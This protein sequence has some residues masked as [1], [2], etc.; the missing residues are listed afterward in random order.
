MN[1]RN[2]I[3]CSVACPFCI[4]TAIGQEW[5]YKVAG[6]EKWAS[7]DRSFRACSAGDQ[8]SPIDLRGGVK[9]ELPKL[10]IRATKDRLN[11]WNNGHTLQVSPPAESGVDIGETRLPLVQFHFHTPSEHSIA[12]KEAAMEVHFV[13]RHSD[14]SLTVLAALLI[15]SGRN[16]TFSQIMDVAPHDLNAKALTVAPVDVRELL[17]AKL[18]LTWRYEGSLTTPPCSETVNWIVFEDLVS[19]AENDI[20]RFRNIFRRNARP[21][22]PINRRYVLKN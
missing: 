17:P 5:D 4:A 22:Q 1:R 8:Q 16:S 20:A 6:P 10:R 3:T 15:P 11:I 13:Y 2:F 9:A 18:D 19:V 7:L 21:R 12:G 14:E